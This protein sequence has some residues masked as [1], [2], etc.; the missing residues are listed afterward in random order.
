MA[1]SVIRG[2]VSP[3][4]RTTRSA[5]DRTSWRDLMVRPQQQREHVRPAVSPSDTAGEGAAFGWDGGPTGSASCWRPRWPSNS[6]LRRNGPARSAT[7]VC[8]ARGAASASVRDPPPA[9]SPRSAGSVRRPH[10]TVIGAGLSSSPPTVCRWSRT[11]SP[12]PSVVTGSRPCRPRLPAVGLWW[13]RRAGGT[14][15]RCQ[16][17]TEKSAVRSSTCTW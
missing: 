10:Q 4:G 7:A 14:P 2:A 17:V 15:N 6:I 1:R 16:P 12:R 11:S 5:R 13:G 9:G 3:S 8:A